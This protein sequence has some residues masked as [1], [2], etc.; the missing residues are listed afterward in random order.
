MTD[1]NF[2]QTF[3]AASECQ[4]LWSLMLV[5]V[6][7]KGLSCGMRSLRPLHCQQHTVTPDTR[8]TNV[9]RFL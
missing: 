8:Y 3:F 6:L 9:G 1:V 2:V 4:D 5:L 7:F